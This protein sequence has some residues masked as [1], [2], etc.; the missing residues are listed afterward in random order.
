MWLA[1]PAALLLIV[2][3][4]HLQGTDVVLNVMLKA[5]F[6]IY[7]VLFLTLFKF[8]F[9]DRAIAFRKSKKAGLKVV[10]LIPLNRIWAKMILFARGDRL[11]GEWDRAY[12]IHINPKIIDPVTIINGVK[13]DILHITRNMSGLF[14]W[15]T[16]MA[17]PKEV[18]ELIGSKERRNEGFWLKG[19]W[20]PPP[21]PFTGKPLK[22]GK[23]AVRRGAVVH[24][25][26]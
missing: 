15:E 8:N 3:S 19:G 11:S 10:T 21:P 7:M 23:K 25:I 2:I 20:F 5:V 26:G 13:N 4:L 24:N 14:I 6:W 1:Y 18:R 12:E 16:K 22:K 9:I 17:I